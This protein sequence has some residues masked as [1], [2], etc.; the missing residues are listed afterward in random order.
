MSMQF[1][2][3]EVS[4]DY[5]THPPGIVNLLM[6]TVTYMQAMALHIHKVGSTTIQ[7]IALLD[8]GHSNQCWRCD[9]NAKYWT[10][11]H[12]SAILGQCVPPRR[13][14]DVTTI[15]MPTCLSSSSEVTA[16]FYTNNVDGDNLTHNILK[17]QW[18]DKGP[19]LLNPYQQCW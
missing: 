9:E 1:P 19:K 7:R 17:L 13:L 10:R 3:S 14:P 11:T 16:Y 18:W 8:P 5:Y 2:T 15:P 6:P 4:A 12:I